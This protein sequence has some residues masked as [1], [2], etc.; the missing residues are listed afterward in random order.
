MGCH[1]E[2]W[3]GTPEGLLE[4]REIKRVDAHRVGGHGRVG[5]GL[6]LRGRPP[7][8]CPH[9]G[10]CVLTPLTQAP[11][12]H[13]HAR[14]YPEPQPPPQEVWSPLANGGPGVPREGS[15][16][17][18]SSWPGMQAR[19][20]SADV[21]PPTAA[22]RLPQLGRTPRL[23]PPALPVP[24]AN[25]SWPEDTHADQKHCRARPHLCLG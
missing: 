24:S 1:G 7:P 17:H 21:L 14:S 6:S 19:C 25:V 20:L 10:T 5:S 4:G 9:L 3:K 8:L 18:Y 16:W 22:S 23:P 15:V 11:N 12:T 13:P 2:T